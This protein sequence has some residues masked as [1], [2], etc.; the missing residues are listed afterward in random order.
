MEPLAIDVAVMGNKSKGDEH[1]NLSCDLLVIK[2][3]NRVSAKN[4][5]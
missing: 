4:A 2:N 1:I 3:T 5:N